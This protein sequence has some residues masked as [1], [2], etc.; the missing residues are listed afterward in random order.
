[1]EVLASAGDYLYT[2][3]SVDRPD[4]VSRQTLDRLLKLMISRP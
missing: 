3:Q 4:R 2:V 1:L